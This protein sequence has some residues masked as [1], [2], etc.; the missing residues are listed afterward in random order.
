MK[1]KIALAEFFQIIYQY[2]KL[3]PQPK[4][5]NPINMHLSFGDAPTKTIEWAFSENYRNSPKL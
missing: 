2:C 1:S 3:E 4:N 5:T